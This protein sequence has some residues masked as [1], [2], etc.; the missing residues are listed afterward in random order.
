MPIFVVFHHQP[1]SIKDAEFIFVTS[2]IETDH[3]QAKSQA[4]ENMYKYLMGQILHF[5]T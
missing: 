2:D 1:V 5:N 4:G 3:R